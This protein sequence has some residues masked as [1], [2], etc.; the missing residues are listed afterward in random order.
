LSLALFVGS[1]ALAFWMGLGAYPL[2]KVILASATSLQTVG[3]LMI[4][5]LI[6]VMSK[7]MKEAGQ[8]ERLVSSFSRL[9]G[10]PRTVGSVMTA[11]I[12]LLPMPGGALFSAPMVDASLAALPV[13][14][15]QKTIINYWFRHLW[16]YWWPIYPGVILALALLKVE[17][18]I[19]ISTMAPVTVISVLAGTLF[20]LRPI[21]LAQQEAKNHVSWKAFGRFLKE[22][23]PILI[24]IFFIVFQAALTEIFEM[25]G[26]R[27]AM[28]GALSILPG[29]VAAL[30]WVAVSNHLPAYRIRA[31]L[32]D[33]G[34]ISILLLIVAIMIFQGVLKESQAALQIRSELLAYGIPVSL[35]IM[36]LPFIAGFITGIAVG[37]VGTSFPL[38]IP[39]FPESNLLGYLSSAALA[40]TF[41]FMGMMLSP[42]HLCFLV[43]KDY[44]G[45]SLIKSYRYLLLPA[46]SVMGIVAAVYFLIQAL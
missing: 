31:S 2:S 32:M 23:L 41:G 43:T 10:D 28:P 30:V 13:N 5:W 36:I 34:S 7:I 25:F 18:W 1:L 6:M 20:I 9:S 33:Q 19:Y 17:T 22:I 38:I 12:G 4:V 26:V 14:K 11:L 40:F 15:E 44:Y 27:F 8:M 46:L 16:E 3:I 42:V 24:I 21:R 35:V 39:M 29:L 37:F 45:A